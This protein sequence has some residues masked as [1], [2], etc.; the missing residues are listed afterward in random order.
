MQIFSS[1]HERGIKRHL[2]AK[3][4]RARIYI[5]IREHARAAV[6]ARSARLAREIPRGPEARQQSNSFS[7][8]RISL[9]SY[10]YRRRYATRFPDRAFQIRHGV[11]TVCCKN[12]RLK[13]A[14]AELAAFSCGERRNE[15]LES[16]IYSQRKY[17][18]LD[19]LLN[20]LFD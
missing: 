18:A 13:I 1:A 5:Y 12:C 7:G 19:T 14:D 17:V 8:K 9:P 10:N 20:I 11:R 4:S 16:I 2:I 15:C 3:F 6:Y